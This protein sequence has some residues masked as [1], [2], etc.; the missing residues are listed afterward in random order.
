ME[1]ELIKALGGNRAV[2]EALGTAP[3]VVA[4]WQQPNRS[5]PWKR[6]HAIARIAAER[7]VP[8]PENFW[9]EQ[10]A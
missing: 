10:A 8:L 7:G 1:S 6:R 5:I 4:N 9:A 3:N 2:A